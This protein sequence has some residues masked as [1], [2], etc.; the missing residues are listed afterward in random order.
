MN[1]KK[2]RGQYTDTKKRF[3]IIIGKPYFQVTQEEGIN[4]KHCIQKALTKFNKEFISGS[5]TLDNTIDW[6]AKKNIEDQGKGYSTSFFLS[7][8]EW[9]VKT[10]D[11]NTIKDS[12]AILH[13]ILEDIE[14]RTKNKMKH[15]L[16][17]NKLKQYETLKKNAMVECM[18]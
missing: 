16:K 8:Y 14:E 6:N 4:E 17:A 1:T 18:G 15:V 12:T 9:E 2:C 10:Y 7:E 13:E 11:N 5:E 3:I